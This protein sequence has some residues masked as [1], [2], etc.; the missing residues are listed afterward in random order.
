MKLVSGTLSSR[1]GWVVPSHAG[2]GKNNDFVRIARAV[3]PVYWMFQNLLNCLQLGPAV[4]W[5]R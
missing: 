3:D 5:D 1:L 2:V 4:R